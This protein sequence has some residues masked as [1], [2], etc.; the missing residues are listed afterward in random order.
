M[1]VA[2]LLLVAKVL[3]Q[4]KCPVSRWMRKEE[5]CL[6]WNT[7]QPEKSEILPFA[8][9]KRLSSSSSSLLLFL[10]INLEHRSLVKEKRL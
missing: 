8:A 4:L 2:L 3:K 9:M 7:T 1:F 6:P 10:N 5:V